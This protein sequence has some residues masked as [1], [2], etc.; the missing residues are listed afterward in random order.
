[1]LNCNLGL[2]PLTQRIMI[3]ALRKMYRSDRSLSSWWRHQMGT[4]STLLTLCA[5]NSPVID[6]FSP[7]TPVTW[8]FD[9][10]FDL[11]MNKR[12]RWFE[13]P[14]CSLWL[15]CNDCSNFTLICIHGKYI[16][17]IS[18]TLTLLWYDWVF[19][20][21]VCILF[22]MGY[23]YSYTNIMHFYLLFN[24]VCLWYDEIM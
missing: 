6:E 10:F 22:E 24:W 17:S 11:C 1:M 4:F 13:T 18:R 15:H 3:K 9:I 2:V 8:S 19:F 20:R 14:S 12:H 7:H 5:G 23:P 21:F 16:V